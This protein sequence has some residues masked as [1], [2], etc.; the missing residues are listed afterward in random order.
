MFVM[1]VDTPDPRYRG[2]PDPDEER[3]RRWEPAG[4]R[5]VLPAAGSLSCLAA[6]PVTGSA[7]GSWAM[8]AAGIA[9]CAQ[10]VREAL[11][12]ARRD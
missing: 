5:L 8:T 10:F 12:D 2:D 1:L 6:A 4:W 11:K 3:E 9:L 7:L